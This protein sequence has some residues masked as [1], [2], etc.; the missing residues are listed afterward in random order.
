MSSTAIAAVD[1]TQVGVQTNDTFKFKL[2]AYTSTDAS[3]TNH[4]Y[5]LASDD[6]YTN[7]LYINPGDQFTMKI[8]DAKPS[9]TSDTNPISGEQVQSASLKVEFSTNND[10][11][12]TEEYLNS[13]FIS[14]T[15]WVGVKAD[16]INTMDQLKNGNSSIYSGGTF[17][18]NVIDTGSEF[19]YDLQIS[20]NTNQSGTVS[21]V[22]IQG[23]V[24]YDKNTGVLNSLDTTL[25][26]QI[27]SS[28]Y[29]TTSTD[30]TKMHQITS[31]GASLPLPGFNYFIT[32]LSLTTIMVIV[33]KRN[34][35]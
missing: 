16:F 28:I 18:Y 1:Y 30:T 15:D 10:S 9:I 14:S 3:K 25:N 35:R 33:R 13:N 29:N 21:A 27:Q 31:N 22:D 7:Q 23:S 12:Q 6:T 34:L 20:A 2:D 32:I 11:I 5:L 24:R 19:G 4:D 8:L 17:D 26:L